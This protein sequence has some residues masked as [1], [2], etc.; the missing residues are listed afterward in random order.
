MFSSE[1]WGGVIVMS[2][3]T[4]TEEGGPGTSVTDQGEAQGSGVKSQAHRAHKQ[5]PG[6]HKEQQGLMSTSSLLGLRQKV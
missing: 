5:H 2:K 6:K 1:V 3:E 4:E